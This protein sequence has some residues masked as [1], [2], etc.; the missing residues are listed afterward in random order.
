MN[1]IVRDGNGSENVSFTWC[2]SA[3]Y[4]SNLLILL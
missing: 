1:I 3:R 2:C 4:C